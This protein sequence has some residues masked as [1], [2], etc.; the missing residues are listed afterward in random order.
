MPMPAPPWRPARWRQE[1]RQAPRRHHRGDLHG[2]RVRHPDPLGK[3]SSGLATWLTQNGYRI[4]PGASPVLGSYSGAE[5]AVLRRQ[6]EPGG[7][8]Q[9][10]VQLPAPHPDRL[11]VA[12]VHAADPPRHGE[13]RRP[14]GA[15]RLRADPQ[16]ARRDHQLPHRAA[17]LGRRD[18]ALREERLRPLL[19]GDVRRAGAEA[20]TCATVFLEYAWDMGWC[21]PCAADPLSTTSC[22][23][24][25]CS[26]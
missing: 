5:H 9:A 25:A 15:V 1:P 19:Q 8:G 12:E 2:R 24:W 3:E 6:G 21:D 14:A 22:A 26:G 16:G 18:P 7:A 4:P 13:R 20:E 23:S 17:A 10:R 11:R